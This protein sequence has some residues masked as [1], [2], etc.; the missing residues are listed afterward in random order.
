VLVRAV[1]RDLRRLE[2]EVDKIVAY[3][4]EKQALT[5]EDM[6]MVVAF[7]APLS[8]FDLTDALGSRDCRG[9]LRLLALLVGQGESILGLHA[10]AVRHVRSLLATRAL[11]DRGL[12]V[13]EIC[14]ELGMPDW[15]VKKLAT[16]AARFDAAE[17]TVAVRG[18]AD[19][20]YQMKTS[21]ADARLVLERWMVSLCS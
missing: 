12:R 4:G 10:M 20:E 15:Q 7:V 3:A 21:R 9:A 5:R 1:G 16:Q 18:L 2:R 14:R 19:A 11:L 8:V 17:L 6:E 13:P